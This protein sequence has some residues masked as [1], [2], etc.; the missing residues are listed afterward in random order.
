MRRK[1]LP[2]WIP[3]LSPAYFGQINT[4]SVVKTNKTE[5]SSRLPTVV[6]KKKAEKI[7]LKLNV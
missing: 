6:V 4:K 5:L 1:V 3:P 2:H 7:E